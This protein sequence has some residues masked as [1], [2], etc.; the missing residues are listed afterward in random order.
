MFKRKPKL[1][2]AAAGDDWMDYKPVN[3]DPRSFDTV[4]S[5]VDPE[6]E[7]RRALWPLSS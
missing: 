7:V 4:V 6:A 5:P 2:V 3:L 1:A